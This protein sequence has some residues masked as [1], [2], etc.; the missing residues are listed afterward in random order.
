[1]GWNTLYLVLGII[2]GI[3]GIWNLARQ[4]NVFLSLMGVLWFL[5][6]LFKLY[7]GQVYSYRIL[8]G[9]PEVGS[10]LLFVLMPILLLLAFFTGGRR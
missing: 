1:M 2:A 9:I 6:I 5:I 3:L 7:V 4:R 10:L 8:E